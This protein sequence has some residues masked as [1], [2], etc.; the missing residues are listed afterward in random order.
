MDHEK[1]V[2]LYMIAAEH[3]D[4][5]AQYNL[6]VSLA[7]G[8]GIMRNDAEAVR[9][10]KLAAAQGYAKAQCALG[11]MYEHGRGVKKSQDMACSLYQ[12]AAAQGEMDAAFNLASLRAEQ[13][14]Y[15]RKGRKSRHADKAAL[16]SGLLACSGKGCKFTGTVEDTL[17]HEESCPKA[18]NARSS[19]RRS[20][21]SHIYAKAW[22]H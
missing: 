18:K 19:K 9:L 13:S 22:G 16:P 1:A 14:Q 12:I 21:M 17:A 8:R 10:Y 6:A 2:E 3:G 20:F 15:G 5:G 4:S 11:F 7:N